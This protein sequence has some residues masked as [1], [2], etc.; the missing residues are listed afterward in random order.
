M[1]LSK[2]CTTTG[3]QKPPLSFDELVLMGRRPI[4]ELN[5]Q[6]ASEYACAKLLQKYTGWHGMEGVNFQIPVGR[7]VFDFRVEETFVEYHPISLRREFLTDSLSR[8]SSVLQKLPKDKKLEVLSAI[9][10][11]LE[12][13][14]AKRRAQTLAA[15][16]IYSRME[17]ICVHSPQEFVE[18]VLKRFHQ[19]GRLED[20]EA[21]KEFRALQRGFKNK[22]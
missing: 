19:S 17:L 15:H 21:L 12:A 14:Y 5:F 1:T 4:E 8:I 20:K 9:S 16:T 7:C 2:D 10:D 3:S 6:S 11:E 18:K 22:L 13:Q